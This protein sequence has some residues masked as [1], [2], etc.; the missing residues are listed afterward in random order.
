M[1]IMG[2]GFV[3]RERHLIPETDKVSENTTVSRGLGPSYL[4]PVIGQ[5]FHMFIICSLLGLPHLWL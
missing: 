5:L 1:Y 3:H 4:R 2:I